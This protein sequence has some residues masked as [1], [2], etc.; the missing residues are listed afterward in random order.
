MSDRLRSLEDCVGSVSRETFEAILGFERE[1]KRWST[2]INLASATTLDDLWNR[3]I[4]DSAQIMRLAP[5]AQRWLDLGSGGGFPGAIIAI[6]AKD[7]PGSNVDLVESNRKKAAFLQTTLGVLDAPARVHAV[8]IEQAVD[9]VLM[10]EIVTAR[11]LA[12]LSALIELSLPW[13]SASAT[14]LFHKGR[15]YQREIAESRYHW[16]FNLVDH[17]SRVDPESR[18]LE[19]SD[20]HPLGDGRPDVQAA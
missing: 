16:R 9:R 15:D 19:I 12:P 6:L 4:I 2:R 13:V 10:P 3:H 20:V 17:V 18:I 11:A 7:R 14:A 1:F 5:G 8:R